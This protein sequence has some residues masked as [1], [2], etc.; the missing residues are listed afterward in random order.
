VERRVGAGTL[1]GLEVKLLEPVK[2]SGAHATFN[3]GGVK[4][5]L[6]IDP[7]LVENWLVG[8]YLLEDASMV[9]GARPEL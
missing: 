1:H 4:G 6:K 3:V 2:R 9:E 7:Y 5:K 8:L